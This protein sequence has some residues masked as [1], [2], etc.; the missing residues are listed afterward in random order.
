MKNFNKKIYA[1]NRATLSKIETNIPLDYFKMASKIANSYSKDYFTSQLS[2]LYGGR[3]AEEL[4]F[5]EDMV[6]TGASNDIQRATEME[7]RSRGMPAS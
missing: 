5:G 1:I 2:M 7:L 3:I 6:T 4:I